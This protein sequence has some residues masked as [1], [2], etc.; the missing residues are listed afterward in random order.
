MGERSFR[1]RVIFANKQIRRRTVACLF[2]EVQ[3]QMHV[4]LHQYN[5]FKMYSC[6]QSA[7]Q[8]AKHKQIK[9]VLNNFIWAP[10]NVSRESRISEIRLIIRSCRSCCGKDRG[11]ETAAN[12]RAE[13]KTGV[14]RHKRVPHYNT[15][16]SAVDVQFPVDHNFC[17]DKM[18]RDH[19]N[20]L[21][22][23]FGYRK[24]W[25]LFMQFFTV[26]PL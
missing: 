19:E 24:L 3:T 1:R 15:V 14:T 25:I 13:I 7:R 8:R 12:F 11:F 5:V 26:S 23:L 6:K 2:S 21:V 16:L 22:R 9:S 18:R 20:I 10:V 17:T 4:E